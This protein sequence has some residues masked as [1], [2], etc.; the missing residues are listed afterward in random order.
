MSERGRRAAAIGA[1]VGA[2]VVLIGVPLVF[3]PRS[4]VAAPSARRVIVVTPH[5][6]QIR[7]EFGRG[8]AAWH[9]RRYGEPAVVVWN[10]PGGTS[11]IS[12]LLRSSWEAALAAG[13]EPGGDADVLFGG[14][15]FEFERLS[16]PLVVE[17][18]AGERSASVLEPSGFDAAWL[19]STYGANDIGGR[20]LY[21]AEGRWLGAALSG[22]GIVSNNDVLA[23]LGVPAPATWRD[24]ADPRL[25]GWIA[26]V[27]PSQSS[28]IAT[29]MEAILEREGWVEGWRI[30]RRATANARSYSASA[31]RAP[32][33]V[34][35]G[36]AAAGICI[37]FYGRAQSQ[38]LLD[39][40]RAA[41]GPDA[42]ERVGYVD[43]VG[44]TV[45]DSDPIA[46]L[47]NPVD[48]EMARRFIEF[49]LSDEG[50]ALWQFRAGTPGGPRH[51]ELRRMPAKRSF[52]AKDL[53]RFVD[54]V[55]PFAIAQAPSHPNADARL[56]IIPLFSGMSMDLHALLT[57]AWRRIVEHPAYPAH[58][59][60]TGGPPGIVRADQVDDPQLKRWLTLFDTMPRV[61]GP[62]GTTFDLADPAQLDAVAAGW[63]GKG[64]K[65]PKWADEG[66]WPK[67]LRGSEALRR[68]LRD[69]FEH[70]YRAILEDPV[71]VE[72]SRRIAEP[73]VV[74]G[75]ST[76]A[77]SP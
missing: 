64:G 63:I 46:V 54:R 40:D 65:P 51:F 32:I 61:P 33:D 74:G 5:N 10:T 39:A 17:S 47:R 57:A 2:L 11:E 31:S 9:E 55:D 76:E 19:A 13:R 37:D 53:D 56:F 71:Q 45:I 35:Q 8:F 20:R 24:L 70:N 29:A 28:S 59:G 3:R 75:P 60:T 50:Q 23:R 21:D 25:R 44:K 62:G 22:F 18:A 69:S 52:I 58:A 73:R 67:E 41:L 26:M 34:S 42:P 27:N 38:A 4:A 12:R 6:E 36:D 14:G 72:G 30:L 49:V 43:P 66:L 7:S 16:K 48:R 1:F 68:F 77:R 15:S